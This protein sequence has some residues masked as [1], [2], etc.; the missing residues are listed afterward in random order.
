MKVE[1]LEPSGCCQGVNHAI[2]MALN[3]SKEYPNQAIT[4]LG[5]L[6]HNEFVIRKL[7]SHHIH[8][9]TGAPLIDLLNQVQE[10]VVI[11]TAH[12]H[13]EKLDVIAKSKG[14]IVYDTTCAFVKYNHKLIKGALLDNHQ[15]IFIGKKGHP[16]TEA[17]LSLGEN[18]FLYDIL[19]KLDYSKITDSNPVVICQ[20]TISIIEVEDIKKDILT[21]IKEAKITKSI[22]NATSARQKALQN[23]NKESDI[24][25]VVGSKTSSNT[26]KLFDISTSLYQDKKVIQIK[27]VDDIIDSDLTNYHYATLVGGASTPKELLL[28][29]K[30]YLETK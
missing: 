16:E 18:V 27:T 29:I 7:E 3:A 11:F 25:I 30:E 6:V 2:N 5:M 12:G 13:D 23:I 14:L 8:T 4:I 24:I 17:S 21:H 22:C 20:T 10:G 15:V 9:L 19:N 1:I 28:D 26:S